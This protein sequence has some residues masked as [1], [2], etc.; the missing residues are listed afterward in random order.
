MV[1]RTLI[2]I[3]NQ[4]LFDLILFFVKNLLMILSLIP[5]YCYAISKAEMEED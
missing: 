2:Q 5:S 4:V 1:S 3:Y